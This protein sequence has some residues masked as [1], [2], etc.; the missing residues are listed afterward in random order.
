VSQ[1]NILQAIREKKTYIIIK[2][3]S[4]GTEPPS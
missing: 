3:N 4:V 1:T 2:T